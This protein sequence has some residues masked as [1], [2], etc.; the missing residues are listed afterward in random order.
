MGLKIL[1]APAAFL[2]DD[3]S[4][5]AESKI[6]EFI[7]MLTKYGHRVHAIVARADLKQP[8]PQ[9]LKLYITQQGRKSKNSLKEMSY[10]A[11]FLYDVYKVGRSI[12]KREDI[13]IIHHYSRLPAKGPG[14]PNLLVLMG[15]SQRPFV[16]GPIQPPQ[17]PRDFGEI[18]SWL[19]T[20]AD[21]SARV[22]DI[23]YGMSEKLLEML[24][25]K[26]F[27][28]A[29]KIICINEKTKKIAAKYMSED[30]LTVIPSGVDVN[31]FIPSY[32]SKSSENIK[33][34]SVGYLLKRKG[35]HILI[36]AMKKVVE[37]YPKVSLKIVGNGP[38]FNNLQKLIKDLNLESNIA[39]CG[40][41]PY[42]N[43]QKYYKEAGYF[44]KSNSP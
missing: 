1:V 5:S 25:L 15:K 4:G 2:V 13:D 38:E 19:K 18:N 34:L 20:R 28:K 8:L 9:N 39:L 17:N 11:K 31:K 26:T 35:F 37:K 6:F 3:K 21:F 36:G 29:D 22:A 24:K 43:I 10:R 14:S 27:K 44:C 30:K 33:L 7:N 12:L 42:R 16:V 40:Y 23:S 41:V 32:P